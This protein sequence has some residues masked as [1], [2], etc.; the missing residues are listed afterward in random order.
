[1]KLDYLIADADQTITELMGL[2]PD[3]PRIRRLASLRRTTL[4]QTQQLPV[5]TAPSDFSIRR[6]SDGLC[7]VPVGL[8]G[9]VGFGSIVRIIGDDELEIAW[10]VVR[11]E[12]SDAVLSYLPHSMRQPASTQ[13]ARLA[14]G[15]CPQCG[16][17]CED[18]VSAEPEPLIVYESGVVEAQ[19]HRLFTPNRMC[20]RCHHRFAV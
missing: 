8:A 6:S 9:P 3:L 1:V 17:E 2:H 7:V 11:F 18:V 13:A 16:S 14:A 4:Q 10:S 20:L 19:A 12:G 15:R 5:I